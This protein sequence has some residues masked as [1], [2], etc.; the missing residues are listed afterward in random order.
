MRNTFNYNTKVKDTKSRPGSFYTCNYSIGRSIIKNFRLEF[1]GYLLFQLEEDSYGG[2]HQFYKDTYGIENTKEQVIGIGP[3]IVY[4]TPT[5]FFLEAK[6]F[7]ETNAE[8]RFQ[9][10][11]PTLRVIYKLDK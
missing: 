5:R 4:V 8:N 6:V 2:D 3:G 7:F 9:G 10:Y 11:R 1:V